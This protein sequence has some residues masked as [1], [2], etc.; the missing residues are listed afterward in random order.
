M[1]DENQPIGQLSSQDFEK[2]RQ[3]AISTADSIKDISKI[4]G[5]NARAISKATGDSAAKF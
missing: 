5:D 3:E 1:A 2:M 4:I